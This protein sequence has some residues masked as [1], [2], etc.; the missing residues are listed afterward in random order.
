VL[1]GKDVAQVEQAI[2]HEIVRLRRETVGERELEKAK[3]QLEAAF[4]FAQD[5]FFAQAMLLAEHEIASSWK[6]IDDYTPSLRKVSP[7]DIQRVANRYLIPDNRTVGVLIP[8]PSTDGQPPP[9][10]ASMKKRLVR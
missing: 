10:A 8:L 4:I 3:N 5:A 9:A 7:E 6:A 2:D 1:P